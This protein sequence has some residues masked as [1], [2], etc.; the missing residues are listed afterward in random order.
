[1]L[2]SRYCQCVLQDRPSWHSPQSR[3]WSQL[4]QSS[5]ARRPM[6]AEGSSGITAVVPPGQHTGLD[7]FVVNALLLSVE[8]AVE[9]VVGAFFTADGGC[10]VPLGTEGAH[11]FGA[12]PH[13]VMGE[14]DLEDDFAGGV[15]AGHSITSAIRGMAGE[16]VPGSARACNELG[17]P[18]DCDAAHGRKKQA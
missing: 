15:L 12:A 10:G 8:P 1:M 18:G 16:S 13:F 17:H 14:V 9:E 2:L 4:G 6:S 11:D 5:Q 3:P 7:E